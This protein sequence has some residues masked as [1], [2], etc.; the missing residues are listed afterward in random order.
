MSRTTVDVIV[1]SRGGR[2][3]LEQLGAR[4]SRPDLDVGD[5]VLRHAA[6]ARDG[7]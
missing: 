7:R 5:S 2:T 4:L 3:G 1:P 6:L